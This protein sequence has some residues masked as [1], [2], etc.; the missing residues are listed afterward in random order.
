MAKVYTTRPGARLR[1]DNF[2]EAANEEPAVVPEHVGREL[3]GLEGFRVEFD[4]PEPEAEPEAAPDE[5]P[6]STTKTTART[7]RR[8]I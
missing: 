2:G 4:E 8:R 5:E 1:I 6:P 7:N 3:D